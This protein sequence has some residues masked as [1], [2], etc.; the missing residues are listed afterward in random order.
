MKIQWLGVGAEAHQA[1]DVVADGTPVPIATL[2]SDFTVSTLGLQLRYR[3]EFR[4]QS[5]FYAVYSRGGDG[6]LDDRD[7]SLHSQ[8]RRAIDQT[9]TS[10]FLF[11]LRYRI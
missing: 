8:L 1:F 6:S 4:P 9:N 3:F 7:E 11:K 2:P 5:D 10:L